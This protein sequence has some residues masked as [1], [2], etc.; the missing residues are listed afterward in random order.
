MTNPLLS[1]QSKIYIKEIKTSNSKEMKPSFKENVDSSQKNNQRNL[2][3][4]YEDFKEMVKT[5]QKSIGNLVSGHVMKE[6][7]LIK[8]KEN[9]NSLSSVI[10]KL[11]KEVS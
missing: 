2:V 9:S 4:D 7:I 5:K 3:I 11:K 6:E 10:E 8:E 1:T